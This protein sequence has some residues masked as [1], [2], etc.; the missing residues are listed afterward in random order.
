MF[1]IK[2]TFCKDDGN[3]IVP[4]TAY[5]DSTYLIKNVFRQNIS[6]FKLGG[7]QYLPLGWSN[8]QIKKQQ[9]WFV[10]CD[11]SFYHDLRADIYRFLGDFSPISNPAKRAARIGQNFAASFSYS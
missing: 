11:N 3:L 7:V 6:G 10:N 5:N 9:M 1:F 4:E 2:V 8:S